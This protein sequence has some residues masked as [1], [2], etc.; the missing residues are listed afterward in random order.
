MINISEDINWIQGHIKPWWSV[1]DVYELPFVK[2]K[3]N[4]EQIQQWNKIGY[5]EETLFG[6]MYN[7]SNPMPH[8]V[9]KFKNI[10]PW[11]HF[12]WTIYKMSPGEIIPWHRDLFKKYI[13]IHKIKEEQKIVRSI[14]FIDDWKE[15]HYI[16]I[17]RT[18]IVNWKKGDFVMW[19]FNTPHIATNNGYEDRYTLQLTGYTK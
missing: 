3:G 4:S 6:S 5:N 8:W 1:Y 12:G 11:N 7:A 13:E 15:G 14:V 2:I 18:P 9:E 19:K 17:D 16:E 10:F